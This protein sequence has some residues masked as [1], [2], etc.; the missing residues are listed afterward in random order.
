MSYPSSPLLLPYLDVLI[1]PYT[2]PFVSS[3]HTELCL[4]TH[5]HLPLN[6]DLWRLARACLVYVCMYTTP[7]W[8]QQANNARGCVEWVKATLLPKNLQWFPPLF[9][10]S[11]P[12]TSFQFSAPLIFLVYKL[13]DLLL[14]PIWS[15]HLHALSC[16][17]CLPIC[18]SLSPEMA[19]ISFFVHMPL[20][21]WEIV[22]C[23]LEPGLD[24][25]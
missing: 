4:F 18:G 7:P 25:D 6:S 14:A 19:A 23:P 8:C 5:V 9:I 13:L 3:H 12:D 22:L 2:F 21:H 11:D 17:L 15:L 1:I 10:R 16:L 24:C 20:P